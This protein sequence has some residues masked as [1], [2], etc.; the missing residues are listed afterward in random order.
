MFA[1]TIQN[2]IVAAKENACTR[3]LVSRT[4]CLEDVG[5]S[6]KSMILIPPFEYIMSFVYPF[7]DEVFYIHSTYFRASE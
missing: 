6:R 4:R 2:K 7:H 5:S 1:E 3:K